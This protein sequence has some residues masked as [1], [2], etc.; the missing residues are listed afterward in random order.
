MKKAPVPV[1][2]TEAFL[3][4]AFSRLRRCHIPN[5]VFIC[6]TINLDD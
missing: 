4:N 3:D 1:K 2:D 6:Q 5:G